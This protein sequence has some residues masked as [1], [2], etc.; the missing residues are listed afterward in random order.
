MEYVQIAD[1]EILI[2]EKYLECKNDDCL[3]NDKC[4]D[5]EDCYGDMICLKKM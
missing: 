5:S 2:Q 1:L 3:E 4:D